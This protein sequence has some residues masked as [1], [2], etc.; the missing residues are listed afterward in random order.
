MNSAN[1]IGIIGS[2]N[3][4]HNGMSIN[5]ELNALED[6]SN[7]I[8]FDPKNSNQEHGYISWYNEKWNNPQCEEWNG[9]FIEIL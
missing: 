6:Q 4:T 8:T 9:K 7:I 2:S 5:T 3:F 1:A